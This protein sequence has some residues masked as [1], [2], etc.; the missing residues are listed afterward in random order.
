M[1]WF[2]SHLSNVGWV[3]PVLGTL[4]YA[5]GGSP[6]LKGAVA[7]VR[8]RAPGMVLLI[9]MA[10]TARIQGRRGVGRRRDDCDR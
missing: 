9:A 8:D 3:G 7:E 4:I 10:I 5:W 1:D 2:G 6:F